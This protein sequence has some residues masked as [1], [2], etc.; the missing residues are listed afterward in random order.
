MWTLIDPDQADFEAD[1]SAAPSRRTSPWQITGYATASLLLITALLAQIGYRHLDSISQHETLRPWL[2]S[3]CEIVNCVPPTRQ[4]S[5]LI[6]S[7]QLAIGPHPAYQ[8]ISQM[9]LTFTNTASFPQPLPTIELVFS[10]IRGQAVAGRRFHP[11]QYL[12]PFPLAPAAE[13]AQQALDAQQSL[14]IHLAFA[15]P[16]DEAVNYQVRFVYE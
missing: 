12:M 13:P 8:D 16:A 11:H 7:D 6:V 1:L 15:T 10:D 9:M 2:L 5:R 14:Q 4:D 3:A